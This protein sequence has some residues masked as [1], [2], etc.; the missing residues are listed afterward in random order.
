[1]PSGSLEMI[2]CT[3]LNIA[4]ISFSNEDV[5]GQ[6]LIWEITQKHLLK[7]F[8]VVKNSSVQCAVCTLLPQASAHHT[9]LCSQMAP[10]QTA[11][12]W[13]GSRQTTTYPWCVPGAH[14]TSTP[15]G[16]H[17]V[18]ADRL[19][20][21]LSKEPPAP[22]AVFFFLQLGRCH[23]GSTSSRVQSRYW[24]RVHADVMFLQIQQSS[25]YRTVY[26]NCEGDEDECQNTV[27]CRWSRL[28]RRK[29]HALYFGE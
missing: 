26:C 8:G 2:R 22:D 15:A 6:S 20:P 5:K 7:W 27:T 18:V 24:W 28:W 23:C 10:L 29:A 1:M 19:L 13:S 16:E 25:L 9:V 17:F 12:A 11:E 14:T 21:A 3:G 4:F